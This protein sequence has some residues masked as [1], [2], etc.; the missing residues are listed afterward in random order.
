MASIV[1]FIE[2]LI[3]EHKKCLDSPPQKFSRSLRSESGLG[4]PVLT[5]GWYF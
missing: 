2:K 1:V 4:V 5:G 3:E